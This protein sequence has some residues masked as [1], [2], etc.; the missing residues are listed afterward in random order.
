MGY[1]PGLAWV[2]YILKVSICISRSSTINWIENPL[3][4]LL[5]RIPLHHLRIPNHPSIDPLT[6]HRTYMEE[7][8]GD[9]ASSGSAETRQVR[10]RQAK[11]KRE[12][13]A[14]TPPIP[15]TTR[16]QGRT[17]QRGWQRCAL[18]RTGRE[19]TRRREKGRGDLSELVRARGPVDELERT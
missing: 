7:K 16:R 14:R 11:E 6:H 15:S 5:E 1:A 13:C 12:T 17:A 4:H 19:W 8:Q 3:Y 2:R 18:C 9:R 10:Q